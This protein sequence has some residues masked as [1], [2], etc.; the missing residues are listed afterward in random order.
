MLSLILSAAV[1]AIPT[2]AGGILGEKCTVGAGLP[3]G[4]CIEGL[5]CALVYPAKKHGFCVKVTISAA[6]SAATTSGQV[7]GR[8]GDVCGERVPG[9]PATCILGLKCDLVRPSDKLGYCVKAQKGEECGTFVLHRREPKI[10]CA[11]GLTCSIAWGRIG[12]C[13]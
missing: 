3:A 7:I 11:E 9:I 13:E 6:S 1:A 2:E 12:F 8:L 10:E 4:T 5:Q